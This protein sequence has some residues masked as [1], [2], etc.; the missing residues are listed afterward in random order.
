VGSG[1]TV[2]QTVT[3]AVGSVAVASPTTTPSSTTSPTFPSPTSNTSPSSQVRLINDNGTFYLIF[4]GQRQGITS[5]GILNSYGLGFKDA[6]LATSSDL[7]LP[8]GGLLPPANGSLVKSLQDPTVYLISNGQRYGFISAV[9]FKALGYNFGSV[10]TVTNP[11]LLA[12]PN[13]GNLSG[14]QAAHLPGTDVNLKGTIYWIGTDNRLYGYPS[15]AVYNSWHK[16]NDFS[17]VVKANLADQ[18]LP[19][20]DMVAMRVLQ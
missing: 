6:V 15:L 18:T 17:T 14:F 11:E 10:L 12:L 1:G 20:G 13:A 3:V 8:Q 2:N 5:P 4:N 19:V 7:V 9:V 16:Y